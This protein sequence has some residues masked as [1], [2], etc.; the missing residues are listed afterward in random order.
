M[1][2]NNF[3][4]EDQAHGYMSVSSFHTALSVTW[5]VKQR[6]CN[7]NFIGDQQQCFGC[8][9]SIFGTITKLV[10]TCRIN[11]ENDKSIQYQEV[12]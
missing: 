8:G 4:E 3:Q 10:V 2:E 7:G 11:T 1:I 12:Q 9:H 5:Y 6:C